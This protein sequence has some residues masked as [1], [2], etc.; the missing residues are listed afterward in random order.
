MWILFFVIKKYCGY[1][2]VG[3]SA[4]IHNFCV[5]CCIHHSWKLCKW[6]NFS[7]QSFGLSV[8]FCAQW[9]N[10]ANGITKFSASDVRMAQ[11][12]LACVSMLS[13]ALFRPISLTFCISTVLLAYS[14]HPRT[15]AYSEFNDTSARPMVSVLFLNFW[16]IHLE[17]S[18]SWSQALLNS[19]II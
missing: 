8:S 7:F 1:K 17:F 5:G 10:G 14:V 3:V 11:M 16:S 18:P 12:L 9:Q 4:H 15:H 19:F 2:K 13:L 6:F